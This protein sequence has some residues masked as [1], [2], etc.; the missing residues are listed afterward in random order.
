M[1]NSLTDNMK[2]KPLNNNVLIKTID[3]EQITASG[4]YIPDTAKGKPQKGTIVAKGN[5]S[6]LINVDDIVLFRENAGV[7]VKIDD[8][9]Y[10]LMDEKELYGIL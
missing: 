1:D 4:L 2:F 9:N 6:P 10:L 5:V 8:V 7:D 3:V